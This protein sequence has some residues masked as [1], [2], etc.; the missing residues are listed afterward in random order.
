MKLNFRVAFP[1]EKNDI[2]LLKEILSKGG[3]VKL[4]PASNAPVCTRLDCCNS[5]F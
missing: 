5:L 2:P 4:A 1:K 3:F